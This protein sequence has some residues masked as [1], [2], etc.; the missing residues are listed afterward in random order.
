DILEALG[1]GYLVT[2]RL[3]Q[4]RATLDRLLALQPENAPAWLMRGQ[5]N[6]HMRGYA[7]A[8]HDYARAVELAPDGTEARVT[9][10]ICL[11][12]NAQPEQ[13]LAH[14]DVLLKTGAHERDERAT[15]VNNLAIAIG[16]ATC[17]LELGRTA[18][19]EA[20]L[21]PLLKTAPDDFQVL[22]LRG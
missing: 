22:T 17:L 2:F 8:A 10:A 4:A 16:R 3:T 1:Q 9:L 5:A 18:E 14:F 7:E 20:V 19:T 6:Y 13:A 21:A 11:L 15:P 12:E